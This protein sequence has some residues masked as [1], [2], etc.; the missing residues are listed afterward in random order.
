[1]QGYLIRPACVSTVTHKAREK[2][3][4]SHEYNIIKKEFNGKVKLLYQDTDSYIYE[5]KNADF[6]KFMKN[7]PVF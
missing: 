2:I 4:S 7:N 6:Y 1:M 3:S 5:F